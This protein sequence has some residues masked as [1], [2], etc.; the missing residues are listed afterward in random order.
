MVI[1]TPAD[2]G[3][4]LPAASVAVMEIVWIPS[5]SVLVAT[6]QFPLPS[7]MVVPRTVV[8]SVS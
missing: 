3:E 5:A 2:S 1:A 7:A 4:I 6:L 8:P